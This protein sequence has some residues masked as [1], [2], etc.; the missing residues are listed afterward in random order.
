MA[1]EEKKIRP[2][3]K[4][5]T[6]SYNKKAPAPIA[7]NGTK[8]FGLT[9]PAAIPPAPEL[10]LVSATDGVAE[11]EEE[12]SSAAAEV[13]DEIADE[14]TLEAD[15]VSE[16]GILEEVTSAAEELE[17]VAAAEELVVAAPPAA[18]NSPSN[19]V[20]YHGKPVTQLLNWAIGKSELIKVVYESSVYEETSWYNC[21]TT[22]G[23]E[24]P[25]PT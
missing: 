7:I 12:D 1:K 8:I 24:P 16:A 20:E 18:A 6:P 15:L 10:E 23:I 19:L 2:R 13:A 5:H 9:L 14:T 4:H 25:A 11:A 22:G 17:L 3:V 21:K